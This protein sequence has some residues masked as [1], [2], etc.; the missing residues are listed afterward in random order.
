MIPTEEFR[1]DIERVIRNY[2]GLTV[3]ETIGVL[4]LIK[5][6]VFDQLRACNHPDAQREGPSAT[7]DIQ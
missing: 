4:E 7:P 1:S 3:A 5:Q 2:P 6:Q